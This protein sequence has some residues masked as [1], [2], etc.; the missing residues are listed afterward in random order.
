MSSL[1]TPA[2]AHGAPIYAL[3]P[4]ESPTLFYSGGGDC[5]VAK[6]NLEAGQQEP[7]VVKAES[8]VYSLV[9]DADSNV[10]FIG[11]SD[12]KLHAIDTHSRQELKAWALHRAGVFDLK[13]DP[14]RRRLLAAGGDG[15]LS[16]WDLN[17]LQLLRTV[18]LS[19]GKLRQLELSPDNA[20]LAVADNQGPVH[21]LN[22]DDYSTVNTLTSHADGATAVAWHPTKPILISGGKDAYLRCWN[23]SNSFA[24]ILSIAAHQASI[25][26][27]VFWPDGL[28]MA[29]ASRDKTIK[30]WDA[31]NLDP[32]KRI[33]Y[34]AGGHRHSVNKLLLAGTVLVS[35]GDDRMLQ[36][37]RV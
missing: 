7:F 31:A 9:L 24:E 30:Y 2:F 13:I 37:H 19:S 1:N 20:L 36:V 26:S 25:Y 14:G 8:P 17:T 15:V 27:I 34:A 18:P 23:R 21:V 5:L 35:G 4:G 10:L 11:C 28:R 16:V 22:A 6:W 12:G 33:D 32:I 3:C 29:T